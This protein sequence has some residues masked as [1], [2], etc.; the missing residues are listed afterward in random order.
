MRGLDVSHRTRD[1]QH[2]AAAFQFLEQR[3]DPRFAQISFA[4]D[5]RCRQRGKTA[6]QDAEHGVLVVGSCITFLHCARAGFDPAAAEQIF[7]RKTPDDECRSGIG[8]GCAPQKQRAAGGRA[9]NRFL[10]EH[11]RSQNLGRTDVR[12]DRI[13]AAQDRQRFRQRRKLYGK[14]LSRGE[15]GSDEHF[16]ARDLRNFD[17][18]QIRGDARTARNGL[19]RLSETLQAA[20]AHRLS[21]RFQFDAIA[22]AQRSLHQRARHDRP[23]AR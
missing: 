11:E 3:F 7:R 17:A 16:S 9:F 14:C 5:L 15:L 1:R 20:N 8:N 19:L 18:R 23:V 4:R 12:A 10:V 21:A 2:V 13:A 22:D 6:M